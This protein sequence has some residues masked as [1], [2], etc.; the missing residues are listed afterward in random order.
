MYVM[1][2]VNLPENLPEDGNVSLI[3]D[4]FHLFVVCFLL[5]DELEDFI[6]F[7]PKIIDLYVDIIDLYVD[8]IGLFVDFIGLSVDFIDL[9]VDI[10]VGCVDLLL[11]D[12]ELIISL[13]ALLIVVINEAFSLIL[14][15]FLH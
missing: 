13:L 1:I 2:V 12:V 6:H 3:V 4:F 5:S 11:D 15:C 10:L 8:V 14:N 7:C 9:F